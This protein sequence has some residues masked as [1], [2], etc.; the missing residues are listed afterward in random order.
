MPADQQLQL[1]LEHGGTDLNPQATSSNN[2][3]N[4]ATNRYGNALFY[5]PYKHGKVSCRGI[6][7]ISCSPDKHLID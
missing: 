2:S 1:A 4:C 5:F 7:L 3:N 6:I